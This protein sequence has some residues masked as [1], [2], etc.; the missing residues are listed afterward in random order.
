MGNIKCKSL[1]AIKALE[2][3][4]IT[5]RSAFEGCK[6]LKQIELPDV[7]FIGESIYKYFNYQKRIIIIY[8]KKN[9]I[10]TAN[11]QDLF[12]DLSQS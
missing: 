4:K 9:Q 12:A 2:C 5:G 7:K 3:I 11:Y 1:T 6:S 8:Y 10:F